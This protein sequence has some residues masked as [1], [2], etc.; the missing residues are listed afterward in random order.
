MYMDDGR[1]AVQ[2][3]DHPMNGLWTYLIV[4]QV[5]GCSLKIR[6]GLTQGRGMTES[7]RY[8]WVYIMHQRAAIHDV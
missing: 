8:Q 4:E 1:H 7:V 6:G 3:T 5:L 2:R